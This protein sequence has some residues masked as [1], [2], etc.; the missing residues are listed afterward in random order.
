LY[1]DELSNDYL[2]FLS[3]NVTLPTFTFY[4]SPV[5][6]NDTITGNTVYKGQTVILS[7]DLMIP[8]GIQQIINFTLMAPPATNG[9]DIVA[10]DVVYIGVNLP[11]LARRQF[12]SNLTS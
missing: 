1:S 4:L 10:M 8:V 5:N 2:V 7:A 6:N 11:C 9:I 3:Q 12:S